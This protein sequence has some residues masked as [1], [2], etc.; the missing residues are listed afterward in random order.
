[1][2]GTAVTAGAGRASRIAVVGPNG[3]GKTVLSGHLA[4][5]L[6]VPTVDLDALYWEPEWRPVAEDVF[7]ERITAA[8]A[9][10]CWI[11]DGAFR[12]QAADLLWTHA[13][14]VIWLD[15][16]APVC[17]A[18][19]VRRT[20]RHLSRGEVLW[21]T[22]ANSW[23][24]VV[25]RH[26]IVLW[27]MRDYLPIRR[28]AAARAADAPAGQVVRLRSRAAVAAWLGTTK[29]GRPNGVQRDW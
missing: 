8:L 22:N 17:L 24:R 3:A 15:L 14:L 27:A 20:I 23:R 29:K 10:P 13:D 26:S 6:A 19:T 2:D 1:M 7:L 25:S 4:D 5:L 18:R 12:G 11:A 16:P 9:P 21:G 28:E